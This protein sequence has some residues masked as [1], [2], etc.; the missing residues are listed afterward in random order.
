[1]RFRLIP[2]VGTEYLDGRVEDLS[3]EGVRFSCPDAM[4]TRAGLLFEMLIPGGPPVHSFA[5]VAWVRELPGEDR[6]E[7][8]SRFVDQSTAVR[9][10]IER[11]LQHDADALDRQA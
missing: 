5:R 3:V 4:R 6:F 9:K 2:A 11:H 10:T 8:G 7:V 1:V